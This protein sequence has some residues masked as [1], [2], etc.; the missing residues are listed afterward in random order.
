MAVAAM[1]TLYTLSTARAA[2]L[3]G[4]EVDA[5]MASP[6][7][8]LYGQGAVD[9]AGGGSSAFLHTGAG[10]CYGSGVAGNAGS[11]GTSVFLCDGSSDSRFDGN[12][13]DTVVEPEQ[14]IVT[15]GGKQ[16]QDVWNIK[17]GSVTA[18]D[19]FS[20]AYSFF[21][22]GDSTCD[23]DTV[24]DD[25]FMALAGHRGDNEGDAFWGFELSDVGPTG[26]SSLASNGGATFSLDFNRTPGDL[27]ISFTLV[28]GGT[29]PLLEVFRWNGSTF[30]LAPASCA[31]NPGASQGDSLLRT[32]P[33]SD[34][35]AP[36]WNV[37]VC[38]PTST[39][40]TNTCRIVS[41]AA[42]DNRIAP[43]D[44]TEAVIDFSAFGVSD[45][46]FSSLIF[47]SRSAHPLE[48]AD[49]KD[50]GG[51]PVDTCPQPAA[52]P[53]SPPGS[54]PG[55]PPGSPPGAPPAAP[56]GG[57]PIRLPPTGGPASDG[58]DWTWALAAIPLAFGAAEILRR[59]RS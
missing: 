56:P 18:K 8:A 17:A 35:Q 12:G 3:A 29:N 46:C 6:A 49:L 50:V 31:S 26:F 22:Y 19:D 9:W 39:N 20:H 33:T 25:P 54:P 38:D 15:P 55:A 34:I 16:I 30:A 37:P 40:G 21:W 28:G 32:N 47:T 27:L 10:G 52:P 23:A 57:P 4:F 24:A 13:G 59:R 45:V 58:A 2:N 51:V 41:G 36:P 42:A 14:N 53:G 5:E 11:G 7:N 48:T 43:R 1:A 44:F